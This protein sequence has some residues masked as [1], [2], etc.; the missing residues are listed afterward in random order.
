MCEHS[1]SL[2]EHQ[3]AFRQPSLSPSAILARHHRLGKA[4]AAAGLKYAA[5]EERRRSD[6]RARRRRRAV[7]NSPGCE[8]AALARLL[9]HSRASPGDAVCAGGR[10]GPRPCKE[11]VTT[12]DIF[13]TGTSC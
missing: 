8:V 1:S 12:K 9:W 3:T 11:K 10:A 5:R 13:S 7:N 6:G 2:A 4:G